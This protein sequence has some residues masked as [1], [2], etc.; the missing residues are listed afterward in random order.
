MS[1]PLKPGP[2]LLCKLGSIAIHVD[3]M[4]SP[5]GHPLDK[6]ALHGLLVDP[7]VQEW[8]QAMNNMALIPRKR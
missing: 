8:L 1:D 4:L 2:S 6:M 5:A 3:E 7:E